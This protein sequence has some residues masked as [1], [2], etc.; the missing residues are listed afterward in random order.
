MP[1]YVLVG[2]FARL[3]HMYPDAVLAEPYHLVRQLGEYQR[4]ART[5]AVQELFVRVSAD[6]RGAPRRDACAALIHRP[7][8]R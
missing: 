3:V 6:S 5:D 8:E 4:D 7:H 1:D 2:S